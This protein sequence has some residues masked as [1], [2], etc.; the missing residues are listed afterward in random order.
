MKRIANF[1]MLQKVC[2]AIGSNAHVDTGLISL[3][4][5]FTEEREIIIE[6]KSFVM[7]PPPAKAAPQP[8]STE[9]EGKPDVQPATADKQPA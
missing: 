2:Q 1:E 4:I 3:K 6:K 7:M 5:E 8:S 9:P